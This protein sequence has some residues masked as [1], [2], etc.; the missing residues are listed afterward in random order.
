MSRSPHGMRLSRAGIDTYQQLVVY[1]HKDCHICRAE[2]YSAMTR[3]QIECGGKVIVATLN[4]V[5]KVY[6]LL[7]RRN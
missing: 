7:L 3:I 6:N 5:A 1:M 4:V 2:G